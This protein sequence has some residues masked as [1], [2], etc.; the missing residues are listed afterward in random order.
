M[1]CFECN[2]FPG[3]Y[4]MTVGSSL[5]SSVGNHELCLEQV[6]CNA[7]ARPGYDRVQRSRARAAVL[8][9]N[10]FKAN[11]FVPAADCPTDYVPEINQLARV[12]Y[13]NSF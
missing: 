11:D 12:N 9:E 3:L 4:Q 7:H 2:P 1:R 5:S 10:R 6:P 8:L 13:S